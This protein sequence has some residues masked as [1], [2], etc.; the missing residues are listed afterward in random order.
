MLG[1][2][3]SQSRPLGNN[4]PLTN[5]AGE[6]CKH[7]PAGDRQSLNLLR[8]RGYHPQTPLQG[9]T[10]LT[11]LQLTW[12]GEAS[13]TL[14]NILPLTLPLGDVTTFRLAEETPISD[15]SG[16]SHS[17]PTGGDTTCL[18]WDASRL[19]EHWYSSSTHS[20]NFPL[21]IISQTHLDFSA[22][23]SCIPDSPV[24]HGDR[25]PG[26]PTFFPIIRL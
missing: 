13:S 21:L 4:I 26:I 5:S 10:S 7:R 16:R 11:A 18:T 3:T 9:N 6:I 23:S 1:I 14:G 12:T 8:N 15:L 20:V 17:Q 24:L 2:T 22:P 25:T 19:V